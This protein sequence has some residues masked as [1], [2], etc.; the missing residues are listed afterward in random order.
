VV[1]L[2]GAGHRGYVERPDVFFAVVAAFLAGQPIPLPVQ[3]G[4]AP[5]PGFQGPP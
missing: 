1:Y 5:P 2:P 3:T 4:S